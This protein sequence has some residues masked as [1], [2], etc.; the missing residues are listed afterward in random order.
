MFLFTRTATLV[1]HSGVPPQRA[2]TSPEVHFEL[3]SQPEDPKFLQYLINRPYKVLQDG[4][5]VAYTQ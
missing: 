2:G 5:W 4:N 3:T 1:H